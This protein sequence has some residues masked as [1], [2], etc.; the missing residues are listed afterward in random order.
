MN[1][2]NF[3]QTGGFPLSTNILANMQEAYSLFNALGYLAGELA[4][5]SG[6]VVT[7]GDVSDGVVFIGGEVLPFRGGTQTDFVIIR[8]EAANRTFE[9]GSSKPV[10]HVRYATF[11]SGGAQYAWADFKRIFPTSLIQLFKDDFETRIT[12]LEN[13]PSP[14]PLGLVAIWNRPATEPIPDG[15]AECTDLRGRVPAGWDATDPQFGSIGANIGEKTHTLTAA[16]LPALQGSFQTITRN[17]LTPSGIVNVTNYST[18]NISASP[19]NF[20]HVDMEIKFGKNEPH[21]NIQPTRVV[22]FIEYVG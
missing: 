18:A 19:S 21:N 10:D 4:I 2:T 7:G 22:R 1:T 5:I 17:G 3:N 15:W 11:G 8:D 16:Q 6:C 20:S 9:D 12:A 13:K 14:I